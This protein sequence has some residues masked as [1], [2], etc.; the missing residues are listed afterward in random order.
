MKIKKRVFRPGALVALGVFLGRGAQADTVLDFETVPA[1]QPLN[2]VPGILQSFGD[3]AAASSDGLTVTGFGTP[4]IG[5]TWG[6]VGFGDTR[7]DFYNDGGSVWNAAQLNDSDVGTSHTLTFTPNSA[8][9]RVVV[10]SFNLH[11]YYISDEKFTYNVTVLSGTNVVSGPINIAFVSD[12][13]KHLVSINHTGAVGQTLK[14]RIARVASTLTGNEFEGNAYD[15]AADDITFAQLPESVLP[16][17]PEVVSVSPADGSVGVAAFRTYSASITN[18]DSTVVAGSIQLK[19]DGVAVSPAPTISSSGGLTNVSYSAAGFLVSGSSHLYT[20]TYNDNL[21]SNYTSTAQFT[22][23]NYQT[24]PTSYALPPSA[25]VVRGFTVRTA[26]A[27]TEVPTGQTL[28]STVA[29]AKAQLA[30]TLINTNT[31]QPYTNSADLGP[32]P[33]GS[34]NYDT[35][36]N[37]ADIGTPVTAYGNF[38]DDVTFPGLPFGPNEW[39]ATDASLYL[40]LSPG[41]YRLGVNSDDG[42]EFSAQPPQGVSG[43]PLVLGLFDNGRGADDTLFDFL[44]QT[45]GIYKF[46]LIFFESQ[47]YAN[48][49]LFSVNLANNEKTLINDTNVNAVASYR[50]LKP[51]ITSVAKSGANAVINWAYGTP[52]YQV[53]F[54]TNLTDAVWNNIGSTTSNTTANVPMQSTRGFIRIFY[55]QP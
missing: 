53:Q 20:L 55:V 14:M 12:S 33:D 43:S 46:R 24:L 17:G 26:S 27:S 48:V 25:G 41:Y 49:E 50:V 10:K 19:L 31:S 13:A 21:G 3:N 32:N 54:K 28:D 2:D 47:G 9:A 18:H 29:R 51:Q 38:L 36:L 44:A 4:N 34:F 42:F 52:P 22:V 11:P 16:V 39:F 6:G 23:A 5:L 40:Q 15:I 8:S 7:W 30:G 35:V 37:F 45:S 1:G